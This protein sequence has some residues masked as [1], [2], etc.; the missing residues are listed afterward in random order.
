VPIAVQAPQAPSQQF[1]RRPCTRSPRTRC[2]VRHPWHR[3]HRRCLPVRR[4]RCPD[5]R[6]AVSERGDPSSRT[7]QARRRLPDSK[8]CG[9][10]R[11]EKIWLKWLACESSRATAVPNHMRAVRSTDLAPDHRRDQT[12]T[13]GISVGP[14]LPPFRIASVYEERSA[15]D[16]SWRCRRARRSRA[17]GTC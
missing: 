16:V 12:K 1:I 13:A 9:V 8:R 15:R 5:R 7:P 10:S 14:E 2:P 17:R 3:R 4:C 11:I 6:A